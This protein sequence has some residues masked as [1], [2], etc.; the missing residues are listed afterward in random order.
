MTCP[1]LSGAAACRRRGR[2]ISDHILV[3]FEKHL[4]DGSSHIESCG[5]LPDHV[6]AIRQLAATRPWMDLSR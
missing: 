4:L 6:N 2:I 1:F 3:F 5:G